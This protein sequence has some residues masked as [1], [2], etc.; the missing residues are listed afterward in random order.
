MRNCFPD[1]DSESDDDERV[2]Y[3]SGKNYDVEK[4]L[5]QREQEEDDGSMGVRYLIE[6]EGYPM[7]E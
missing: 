2:P 3:S 6:W 7:H 5:A 4:I 1:S